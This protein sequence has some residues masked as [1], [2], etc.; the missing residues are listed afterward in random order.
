MH[1]LELAHVADSTAQAFSDRLWTE[2][3]NGDG[4]TLKDKSAKTVRVPRNMLIPLPS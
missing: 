1:I 2:I 3:N 4:L